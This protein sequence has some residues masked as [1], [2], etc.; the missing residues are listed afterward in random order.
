MDETAPQSHTAA[1]WEEQ[2]PV[3]PRQRMHGIPDETAPQSLALVR[4]THPPGPPP[5]DLASRHSSP[6]PQPPNLTR[7]G[8][9][10][11]GSSYASEAQGISRRFTSR[12]KG[13]GRMVY[14]D[15][16]NELPGVGERPGQIP[17]PIEDPVRSPAPIEDPR[18]SLPQ[19]EDPGRSPTPPPQGARGV[20][21]VQLWL[22]S[23]TF[24][25]SVTQP[26]MT[27]KGSA[28][29]SMTSLGIY[30]ERWCQN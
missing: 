18:R 9:S 3:T 15:E 20:S 27:F 30:F 21:L 12:S 13:K 25:S 26:K 11:D 24:F 14:S 17:T 29:P 1:L 5:L 23:L 7:N 19:F 6:T 4:L 10:D 28:N 22:S 8:V 2:S 16:E